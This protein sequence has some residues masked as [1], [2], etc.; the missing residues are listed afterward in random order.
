MK[1]L[2]LSLD[3]IKYPSKGFD[4]DQYFGWTDTQT[5]GQ[6]DSSIPLNIPFREHNFAESKKFQPNLQ[7]Y[8]I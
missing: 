6:A 1:K 3:V 5:D 4:R 8:T 2:E 7:I